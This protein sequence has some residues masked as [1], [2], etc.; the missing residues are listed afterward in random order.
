MDIGRHAGRLAQACA[1][2]SFSPAAGGL[3]PHTGARGS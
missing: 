3:S 1:L 2:T